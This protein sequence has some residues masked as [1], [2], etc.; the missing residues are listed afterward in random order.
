MPR[1]PGGGIAADMPTFALSGRLTASDGSQRFSA[2][3]RWSQGL[4]TRILLTTPM[5]QAVASIDV[6]A[7]GARLVTA[8]GQQYAA[9]SLSELVRRG[10]GLALPFERLPWWMSGR[11]APDALA[12]PI[13]RDGFVQLGWT[14]RYGNRDEKGRPLRL[15]A[16]CSAGCLDNPQPGVP[17][18]PMTIRVIIDQWLEP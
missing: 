12:N 2:S 7:G 4:A 5:G 18:G 13:A 3:L 15:D 17:G 6:D 11:G 9:S 1:A 10:L 16:E 8:D 14:V